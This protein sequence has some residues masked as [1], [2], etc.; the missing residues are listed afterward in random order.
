[1]EKKRVLLIG[2]A[3]GVGLAFTILLARAAKDRIKVIEFSLEKVK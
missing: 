3:V 2:V 1:M